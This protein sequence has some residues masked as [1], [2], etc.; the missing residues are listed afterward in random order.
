MVKGYQKYVTWTEKAA[1]MLK[2]LDLFSRNEDLEEIASTNLKYLLV[3]AFQGAIT[4]KQVN[5]R[6]HLDHLQRA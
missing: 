5:P 1:E 6:E 4:M 2:Q 3:P